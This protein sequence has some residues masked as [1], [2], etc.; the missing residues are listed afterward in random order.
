MQSSALHCLE[1]TDAQVEELAFLQF[2]VFLGPGASRD[3]V[4]VV[5]RVT[6]HF[7]VFHFIRVH[8]LGPE[9]WWTTPLTLEPRLSPSPLPRAASQGQFRHD[10]PCPLASCSLRRS[11]VSDNLGRDGRSRHITLWVSG[12]RRNSLTQ[13]VR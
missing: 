12:A 8:E 11:R 2:Y 6:W 7:S 10:L 4:N 1:V 3:W 5:A 9:N 13:P